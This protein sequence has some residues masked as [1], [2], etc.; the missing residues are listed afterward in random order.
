MARKQLGEI[1]PP[2]QVLTE[3]SSD[4]PGPP[5]M[6][7]QTVEIYYSAGLDLLPG[8]NTRPTIGVN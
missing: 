4:R 5:G 2:S 3:N 1:S 7:T 6:D 8:K